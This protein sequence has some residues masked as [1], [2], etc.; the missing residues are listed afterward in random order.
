[1]ATI[2]QEITELLHRLPELQKQRV[3]NFARELAAVKTQG[4]PGADLIGFGGCILPDD[5]QRMAR[6]NRGRLLAAR[7]SV[8][9][10]SLRSL[11]LAKDRGPTAR[12]V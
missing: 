7:I 6:C 5:L 1:M 10:S 11:G 2:D 9:R 12:H 4:I 3:L 8:G